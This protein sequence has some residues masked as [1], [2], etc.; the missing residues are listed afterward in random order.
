MVFSYISSTKVKVKEVA[1]RHISSKEVKQFN[2]QGLYDDYF[3]HEII[4]VHNGQGL[5][6]TGASSKLGNPFYEAC[7]GNPK[8][9]VQRFRETL[10]SDIQYFQDYGTPSRLL[11]EVSRLSAIMATGEY[12][13]SVCERIV[14][15]TY[16]TCKEHDH[17]IVIAKCAKWLLDQEIEV[18]KPDKSQQPDKHIRVFE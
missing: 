10:Y 17:A 15:A 5:V 6:Y 3:K 8:Q 14:M 16:A 7:N 13:N 1:I 2:L 12:K 18:K 11:I 4:M 9:A